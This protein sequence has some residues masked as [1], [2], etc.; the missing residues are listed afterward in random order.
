MKPP[1]CTAKEFFIIKES[2]PVRIEARIKLVLENYSYESK[3]FKP[4]TKKKSIL[5]LRQKYEE[6]FDWTLDKYTGTD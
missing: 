4:Q 5:E 2:R 6:M 3:L 1:N